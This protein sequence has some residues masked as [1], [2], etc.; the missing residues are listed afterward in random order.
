MA[1]LFPFHILHTNFPFVSSYLLTCTYTRLHSTCIRD[2]YYTGVHVKA[3]AVGSHDC[4]DCRHP[5]KKR[6]E[7]RPRN[8]L[9]F[10]RYSAH[11]RVRESREGSQGHK[12][13]ETSKFCSTYLPYH[14]EKSKKTVARRKITSPLCLPWRLPTAQLSHQYLTAGRRRTFPVPFS[15]FPFATFTS[16]ALNPP[17]PQLAGPCRQN[18]CTSTFA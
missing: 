6:G 4:F 2:F 8:L 15:W 10:K 1:P 7:T 17:S 14:M 18:T 3:K 12:L 9:N 5:F 11:I 16:A 13:A